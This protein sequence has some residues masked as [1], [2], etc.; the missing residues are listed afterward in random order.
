MNMK[1][2]FLSLVFL[3]GLNI[4]VFS[5]FSKGNIF[6]GSNLNLYSV[7]SEKQMDATNYIGK[8]TLKGFAISP[9]IGAFVSDN[10]AMGL[11]FIYEYEKEGFK[12]T[13]A[14]NSFQIKSK[15]Y[16]FDVFAR[17]HKSINE[18]MAL[19]IHAFFDFGIGSLNETVSLYNYNQK[20]KVT[21]DFTSCK[22]GIAP[23]FNFFLGK[24]I[25]L[26]AK[27]GFIGYQSQKEKYDIAGTEKI[28]TQKELKFDFNISSLTL[29]INYFLNRKTKPNT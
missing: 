10:V 2:I 25:S 29:G 27:F 12:A 17:T 4:H 14:S 1:A 5:Q 21:G 22:L 7:T 8:D 28:N 13:D 9:Q 11:G 24:K 6:M 3:F 20:Y 18:N 16:S 19:F 15:L 26:E 23:G